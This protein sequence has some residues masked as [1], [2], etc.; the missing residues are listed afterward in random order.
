MT[1]YQNLD[2]DVSEVNVRYITWQIIEFEQV[3]INT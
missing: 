1:P 3:W 2:V